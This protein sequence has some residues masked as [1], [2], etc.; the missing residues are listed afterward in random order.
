MS[1]DTNFELD[2]NNVSDADLDRALQ[3]LSMEKERKAKIQAGLIKGPQKYS[4]LTDEQKEARRLA[5]KKRRARLQLYAI[6]AQEAGIEVTE[7]EIDQYVTENM[8]G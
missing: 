8:A 4:D 2:P 7:A 6:K 5:D 1:E 3:L